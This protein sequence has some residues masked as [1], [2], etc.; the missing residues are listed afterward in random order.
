MA[1]QQQAI[2]DDRKVRTMIEK[3]L[4]DILCMNGDETYY[5]KKEIVDGGMKD[6]VGCIDEKEMKETI[7]ILKENKA[8]HGRVMIIEYI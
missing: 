3:V 6:G 8:T 2:D 7:Y 1:I 5:S 4:G